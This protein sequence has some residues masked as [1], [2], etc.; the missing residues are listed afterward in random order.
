MSDQINRKKSYRWA[1]AGRANYDGT[2]WD[3]S[4]DSDRDYDTGERPHPPSKQPQ[5]LVKQDQLPSLPKLNYTEE[6][7][8]DANINSAVDHK[9]KTTPSRDIT[10]DLDHLMNEISKEMTPVLQQNPRFGNNGVLTPSSTNDESTE[11]FISARTSQSPLQSDILTSFD[12]NNTSSD[13]IDRENGKELDQAEQGLSVSRNGYF[14]QYMNTS[15]EET[16]TDNT[17]SLSFFSEDNFNTAEQILH[18]NKIN[19]V[20]NIEEKTVSKNEIE[21]SDALSYTSSVKNNDEEQT[22]NSIK[23]SNGKVRDEE[24]QEEDDDEE[25]DDDDDEDFKFKSKPIRESILESSDD[26]EDLAFYNEKFQNDK[27]THDLN[28]DVQEEQSYNISSDSDPDRTDIVSHNNPTESEFEKFNG[29][30]DEE[31]DDDES[32]LQGYSQSHDN[33]GDNDSYIVNTSSEKVEA[34]NFGTSVDHADTYTDNVNTD[35]TT[36]DSQSDNSSLESYDMETHLQVSKSGYFNKIVNDNNSSK[37]TFKSDRN[38]SSSN[39]LSIPETIPDDITSLE[40]NANENSNNSVANSKEQLSDDDDND[41]N[42]DITLSMANDSSLVRTETDK[43]H[44]VNRTHDDFEN[45]NN[46]KAV[47]EED[48][49]DIPDQF[50]DSREQTKQENEKNDSGDENTEDDASEDNEMDDDE[51]K[52]SIKSRQSVNLGKWKPDTDSSRSGFLQESSNNTEP[53]PGFVVDENGELIDLT[54]SNMKPRVVSTYSEMESEW[55]VFPSNA[56]QEDLQTIA[57]TKTLYD[58]STI[59]NVPGLITHQNN[60]PPLPENIETTN[61]NII[62]DKSARTPQAD[63]K[64]LSITGIQ[65]PKIESLNKLKHDLNRKKVPSLN[66]HQLIANDKKTHEQKLNDL[67]QYSEQLAQFDTG[68]ETWISFELKSMGKSDK[69]FIFDEYKGSK[70]VK[71]AYANADEVSKKH[72]VSN[73]VANVNQ[74]V[75]HLTKKVFQGRM[76]PKTLFS[77][78]GKGVK[79]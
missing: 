72:T 55:N 41:E 30:E 54:P 48:Q 65:S 2:A 21:D 11:N 22:I 47:L 62:N 52:K 17:D 77:S 69:D 66:V 53:P 57:D 19:S 64:D 13:S 75:T 26:D 71:E 7:K 10:G 46:V 61:L 59:Y 56:N 51:K 27:D 73:T 37:E 44:D 12:K 70:H 20:G 42:F 23:Y 16:D 33:E 49:V 34:H 68:L 43:S 31:D 78:I 24:A 18:D 38:K 9:V 67:R 63:D 32:F 14:E 79:L 39:T 50:E 6:P 1:S 29:V 58:N 45:P 5:G 28:K 60:L 3:S 76:K 74:N 25:E 40:F 36:S 35:D 15:N 4:S 8:R